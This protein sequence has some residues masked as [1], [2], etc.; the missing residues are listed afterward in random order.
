[1]ERKYGVKITMPE[2]DPMLAAHLLGPGWSS[3]R[4]FETEFER[5][6][7][8]EE[9]RHEHLYSR[10]GDIVSQRYETIERD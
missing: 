7:W 3:E 5:D 2:D 10:R 1:M 4:W 8:I 6:E 9:Q